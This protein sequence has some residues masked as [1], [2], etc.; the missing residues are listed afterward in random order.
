MARL[1]DMT[2]TGPRIFANASETNT[3]VDEL[4]LNGRFDDP[5]LER[6]R[7]AAAREWRTLGPQ[8][9]RGATRLNRR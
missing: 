8:V 9:D 5:A 7:Q 3:A 2:G 4:I 6:A 1:T